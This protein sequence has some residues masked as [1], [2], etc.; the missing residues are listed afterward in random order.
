[1][2]GA[3][4]IFFVLVVQALAFAQPHSLTL[5]RALSSSG[6][7]VVVGVE[8]TGP[9]MELFF[10][11]SGGALWSARWAGTGWGE[12]GGT[13]LVPAIE[14]L[15]PGLVGVEHVDI[16]TAL[17]VAVIGVC[18]GVNPDL[19]CRIYWSQREHQLNDIE[20]EGSWS[21]PQLIPA[22]AALGGRQR[23]PQLAPPPHRGDIVF[24]S[25]A[26]GG[27][28]AQGGYD[29][30]RISRRSGYR[31]LEPM[32]ELNSAYNEWGWCASG[33][34][35]SGVM[36]WFSSDRPHVAG[37]RAVGGGLDIWCR[38]QVMVADAGWAGH[39]LR[40]MC[41]GRP[42]AGWDVS[43]GPGHGATT[44]ESGWAPL[45][46]LERGT[47]HLLQVSPGRRAEPSDCGTF[48]A[49]VVAPDGRVIRTLRLDRNQSTGAWLLVLLPL[50][51]IAAF[52]IAEPLDRSTLGG[53][54]AGRSPEAWARQDGA[55]LLLYEKGASDISSEG[56]SELRAVATVM[57]RQP[58]WR[59]QLTSHTSAVGT[60]TFNEQLAW[61]RAESAA[62]FLSTLG[63]DRDRIGLSGR[64]EQE[65]R[66][67]CMEG[68]PCT[69][70][71]HAWNRRTEVKW[72]RS[73]QQD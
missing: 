4:A 70:A 1:M 6:D 43:A 8:G 15:W 20:G 18:N 19:D 9:S 33:G 48:W 73:T 14:G 41:G 64:G 35:A 30:Y 29:L 45:D 53:A 67:H 65:P 46:E 24:A 60:A 38:R 37:E 26:A 57:L 17:W 28:G 23:M 25:D 36:E 16:D 12:I 63:V 31:D 66:N 62:N 2:K 27:P 22:A 56:R 54:R 32:V 52:A 72:L 61:R 42:A 47:T 13:N 21:E 71:E 68:T 3:M 58:H 69:P 44:D 7:D 11:R 40:L 5:E 10:T 51:D 55:A 34:G 39:R 49:E 50:K 59:V